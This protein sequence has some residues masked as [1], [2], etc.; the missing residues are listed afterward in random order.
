MVPTVR[1]EPAGLELEV[2]PGESV[3]E[4]A[5]RQ[6]YHWP[7]QCWGQAECMACFTK[8][9]SGDLEVEPPTGEELRQM[10]TLLPRLWRSSQ[11]RLACRLQIRGPGVVLEKKGVRPPG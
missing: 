8:V 3:A 9:V 6:G 2:A 11:T 10:E 5:W 4:A 1:I 7:T